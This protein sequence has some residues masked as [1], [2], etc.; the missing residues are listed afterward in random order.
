MNTRRSLA[1]I[2]CTVALDVL[3]LGLKIPVLPKNVFAFMGDDTAA[4]GV[5]GLFATVW[6]LVQF[7]FSPLL[8][9]PSRG[10]DRQRLRLYCRRCG[11]A[12]AGTHLRDDRD[13]LR[14][15]ACDRQVL[16]QFRSAPAVL[17]LG[18]RLPHQCGF[19]LFVLPEPPPKRR[20]G[21]LV[22]PR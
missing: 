1:F 3:A 15:G 8:G 22:E 5:F 12:G 19:G 20:H 10:H 11:A 21:L 9:A 16:G 17:D 18:R 6:G 7:L 2:F 14:P 4:A 13:G